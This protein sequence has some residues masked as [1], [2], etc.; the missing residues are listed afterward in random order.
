VSDTWSR[1]VLHQTLRDILLS[2]CCFAIAGCVN[3]PANGPVS[4]AQIR[5]NQA[6]RTRADAK[7]AI[8]YYLDAADSALDS[9]NSSSSTSSA[10]PQ[11][12]YNSA[13]QEMAVLLQSNPALWKRNETI[14]AHGH[15]YRLQ[16]TSGSRQA[17]LWDPSYFDCLHTPRQLG[18]RFRLLARRKNGWGG[19]LVG[20][21]EPADPRKYFLPP[22]G[23]AVPVTAAVDFNP[24]GSRNSDPTLAARF[25]LYDPGKRETIRMD[26]AERPL[27][28]DFTATYS[29]YPNPFLLG[30]QAMLR[31][32]SHRERAG[33]Y[34]LEPY[35]PNQIPVVFVHGLMSVPQMWVPTIDAI[36]SDPELRG[37]FQFWVFAYPTGDPILLSA[38]RLRE[39]LA[40]IYRLYPKT[41]GM[42]LIGHS[43]GGIVSRL[44]AV[45]TGRVIWD[46][47]FKSDADRL[48]A[49]LPPD[50]L[51]KR[52]VIF[53]ANPRVKR[54]VFICVPHR[55][56]YLAANWIGALG[57]S[58]I[59]FPSTFLGETASEIMASLE[60]NA[61]LKR[62]PT[63]INDLSPRSRFPIGLNKLPIEAPYHSI[64]G[65]RGRGDTPNSSD[66]VVA[67]WSSHLEGAQSELIVPGS[68]SVYALPQTVAEL[69][70]I[71]RLHLAESRGARPLVVRRRSEP[72]IAVSKTR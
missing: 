49:T 57:V 2:S 58:L 27:A 45:T 12:I 39:S 53:K 47:V 7:T 69:K 20:V 52:A 13:C 31:P 8:G 19:V 50:D 15:T 34:L 24:V 5:L 68:H 65:D 10:D 66:G 35:D 55:G 21:H 56:S 16:F 14:S 25:A 41:K 64:I 51:V 43:M 32:A 11:A 48:Y 1:T 62:L 6:R 17:G 9:A 4:Q 23:L 63:G 28:A 40:S 46:T 33:L 30:I 59:R 22:H 70:R 60:S 67:Y 18:R 37:Q 36:D 26:G 61:G 44:Q 54:I 42:I 3:P 29:Y 38:L 71:L 72:S